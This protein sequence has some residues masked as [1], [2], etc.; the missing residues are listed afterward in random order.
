MLTQPEPMRKS[1]LTPQA[2]RESGAP[3]GL[4]TRIPR[5]LAEISR[6]SP[7]LATE[8]GLWVFFRSPRQM[9]V[10][11][12]Q[13]RVL[14]EGHRRFWRHARNQIPVWTWGEGP[15]VL[16]LHGWG[17]RASQMAPFVSPLV[18]AGFQAVAVDGPAHGEASGRHTSVAHFASMVRALAS[19][20]GG[21][22]AAVTHSMGGSAVAL[23]VKQGLDLGRAV[24]VAPPTDLE[25][26]LSLFLRTIGLEPAQREKALN[27]ASRRYDLP[28]GGLSMAHNLSHCRMPFLVIHDRQDD[29]ASFAEAES[30]VAALP[31]GQMLVTQGLGHN[32]ILS[33]Q[34]VVTAAL[35]FVTSG[36]AS[37]P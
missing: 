8:I 6:V 10:R 4:A 11:P 26:F 5:A 28:R 25:K 7:R 14:S 29:K 24:F 17:G 1:R 9:G 30:L 12:E 15:R 19:D 33:D 16:L 20:V 37:T 34:Q 35:H 27:R 21:F 36:C 13:G 31:Q 3:P 22:E 32:R 23:A 18:K 2:I